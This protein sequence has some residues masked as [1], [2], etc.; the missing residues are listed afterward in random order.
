MIANMI[1]ILIMATIACCMF[2]S[3]CLAH[4]GVVSF[5]KA[6]AEQIATMDDV[7][8][9]MELAKSIVKYRDEHG[10]FKTP[11]ALLN[12]PGM[13]NDYL[14]E[15]NPVLKDGDVVHDPDAVPALAPSKC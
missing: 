6:T 9:P 1:K 4:G 7:E 5:N 12:V 11:D 13:T 2:I 14:E 10:P 8:I 15:L 3:F